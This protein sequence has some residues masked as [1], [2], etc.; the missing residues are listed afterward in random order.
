MCGASL[1]ETVTAGRAHVPP[2][3]IYAHIFLLNVQMPRTTRPAVKVAYI[4]MSAIP[5]C[6]TRPG[7]I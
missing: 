6:G 4:A 5:H 2:S 7:Q 1:L 3:G